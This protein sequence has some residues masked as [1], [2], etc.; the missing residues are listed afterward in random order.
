[1]RS[2]SSRFPGICKGG[3]KLLCVFL[4]VSMY[5]VLFAFHWIWLCETVVVFVK[6]MCSIVL[7]KTTWLVISLFLVSSLYY[8][9]VLSMQMH[10]LV[11]P[12]LWHMWCWFM[13][14]RG[15]YELKMCAFAF[16][17]KNK[18]C[19]HLGGAQPHFMNFCELIIYIL[20][21][22]VLPSNTK[23]GEIER[24]FPE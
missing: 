1:V 21:I 12:L 10:F 19:V 5:L 13:C 9:L 22:C 17:G 16:K 18:L 14:V 4:I 2:S 7:R 11:Y 23:M 3:H 24:E 15:S 8:F 6:T 20:Q